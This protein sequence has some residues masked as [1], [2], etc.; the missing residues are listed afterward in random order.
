MT[1]VL[2]VDDELDTLNLLQMMMEMS[3]LQAIVTPDPIYALTLAASERPDCILLD[4]MMPQLDGF[5]V[6]RMLRLNPQT[7]DIP[8]I[9]VTAYSALNL[10][11][12]RKES[13]GDLVLPKPVGMNKLLESIE[14]V[15]QMRKH[16]LED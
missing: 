2:I 9:F 13:G 8:I 10:E 5:T 7:Q 12:R 4:I 15:I 1:R 6:C 3:G 14:K 16:V 11:E